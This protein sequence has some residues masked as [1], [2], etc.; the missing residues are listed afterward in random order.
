MR[1]LLVVLV[2]FLLVL[3]GCT[4]EVDEY[5][6]RQI[7]EEMLPT[8]LPPMMPT[9]IAG[10]QGEPGPTGR[11]GPVGIAG[12]TGP[13]GRPGP[14][15]EKGVTGPPGPEGPPGPQGLQGNSGPMGLTGPVGPPG[16]TGET[17]L[18]VVT[19]TPSGSILPSPT[20]S[21]IPTAS[22]APTATPRPTP[23][24]SGPVGYWRYFGPECPDG[25]SNCASFSSEA[26]FVALDAYYD[27]NEDF[28]DEPTL[29]VS[30]FQG[31][32]TLSFNS[33]GPWIVGVDDTG[34]SVT[35]GDNSE[36]EYFWSDLGSD[37]LETIWFTAGDEDRIIELLK[38]ADRL[39]DTVR[40]GVSGDFHTVV[41]DFDVTGVTTN[42]QR[43]PCYSN[44]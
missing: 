7:V 24:A 1:F 21:V 18:L 20:P 11:T 41:A 34:V 23:T 3:G 43:L 25:Y 40:F 9:G 8:V 27:T 12:L 37:D 39:G 36:Y 17:V 38:Q 22:P 6:V 28:Y 35:I 2:F 14:Q 44:A 29:L 31:A 33:G 4:V 5:Q 26:T 10:E 19:P 15:G 30:C 13:A 42:L 32:A 16:P